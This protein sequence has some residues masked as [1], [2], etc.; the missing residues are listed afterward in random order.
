M[1]RLNVGTSEFYD[2]QTRKFIRQGGELVVLE[3]SLLSI[4]KWEETWEK[5]FLS[6]E[7]TDEEMFDYMRCMILPYTF[8]DEVVNKFTDADFQRIGKYINEKKSATLLPEEKQ[9]GSGARKRITSEQIYGWMVALNIDWRAEEWHLNR[10]LTLVRICNIQNSQDAGK[11][12]KPVTGSQALAN[13]R[14]QNKARRAKL[15]SSG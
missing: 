12:N 1:L 2:E 10:L 7:K 5:S 3:H 9:D 11:K 8:D 15:N 13:R 4:S 6:D 14:A